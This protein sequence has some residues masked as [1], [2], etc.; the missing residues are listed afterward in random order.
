MAKTL[1]Y[2]PD[3]DEKKF[4]EERFKDY[5]EIQKAWMNFDYDML[6]KKVTDELYNQ[7]E[8]QLETLQIKKQRNVMSE[9]EYV[10]AKLES[11]KVENDLVAI[12]LWMG[13]KML[14]YIECDGKAVRGSK[15]R[16][17][18]ITYRMTFVCNQNSKPD[19]CP[20]CG[21]K[22]DVNASKCEYCGS[23][24]TGLSNDWVLSKKEAKHQTWE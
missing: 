19:V 9:F 15:Y 22:Y 2:I 10:S 4:L 23:I 6:R 17:I 20:N 8:M 5:V 18:E 21:A 1:S 24:I 14:D 13:V 7:Y 12:T 11:S 16:R 3:G